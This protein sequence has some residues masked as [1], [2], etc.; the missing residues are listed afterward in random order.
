MSEIDKRH[1]VVVVPIYLPTF[2][3][4]ETTALDQ[5]FKILSEYDIVIVKPKSLNLEWLKSFYPRMKT[6]SFDDACFSSIRSYNRLVLSEEFYLAFFD[7]QYMLIYQLDAY[8]FKDDLEMWANKGYDYIGAPWLP[9][10]RWLLRTSGRLYL[11]IEALYY[12]FRKR[13]FRHLRSLYYQIGNGGFSLRKIQKMIEITRFYNDKIKD[14]LS[15]GSEFYPEDVFLQLELKKKFKLKKPTLSGA[16]RF[17]IEQDPVWCFK[18]NK[19]QLPFGC[20]NWYN[21]EALLFWRRFI[22]IRD[23]ALK[24]S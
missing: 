6:M 3:K 14:Y 5:C 10:E 4:F 12:F 22:N 1:I 19:S 18:Y 8:V 2:S 13:S 23:Y 15:D 11:K 7:Y 21:K 16:I 24:E 17:S 20:H 9:T